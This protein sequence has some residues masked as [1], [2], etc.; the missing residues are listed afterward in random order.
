MDCERSAEFQRSDLMFDRC[1]SVGGDITQVIRPGR[2]RPGRAGPA[3]A[4]AGGLNLAGC[5]AVSRAVTESH[6]RGN[7]RTS[8]SDDDDVD[9]S[10][11][12]RLTHVT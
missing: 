11:T 1:D 12:H 8:W 7:T 10:R 4:T 2:A 3:L 9:Q 5:V 6:R